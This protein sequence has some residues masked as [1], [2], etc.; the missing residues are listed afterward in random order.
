MSSSGKINLP[1]Q[2]AVVLD[3]REGDSTATVFSLNKALGEVLAGDGE[4]LDTGTFSLT[5]LKPGYYSAELSL[6]A[7]NGQKT[8]TVKDNFVLLAQAAPVL[9]WVYAKGNPVFPNPQDLAALG[10]QHFLTGQYGQALPMA[11]RALQMRDDP[12][13]R[14]LLAKILFAQGRFQDSVDALKPAEAAGLSRDAG[15]VMA[16]SFAALKDWAAA[17]S[18]LDKLLA[19]ATEVSVLNLAGEC[20]LNSG[21]PDS[22]VALFER[23]LQLDPDQPAIKGLLEKARA[24]IKST[25]RGRPLP[26]S[27]SLSASPS[28]AG[29]DAPPCDQGGGS[30]LEPSTNGSPRQATGICAVPERR[31]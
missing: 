27:A 31:P 19:E 13:I 17:L 10:N 3:I 30:L 28:R 12:D 15:K 25:R 1:P 14:L 29:H 21:R 11:Q 18:Y 16:A 4:G 20:H 8:W 23:S 22:A 5:G 6:I 7:E 2:S 24:G 26:T 9:P